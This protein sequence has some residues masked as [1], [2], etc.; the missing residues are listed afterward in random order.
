MQRSEVMSDPIEHVVIIVKEN[1]GFDTYFGRFP[2]CDGD[3][4]LANAANP[5]AVD[6]N[7]T[8]EGW[9]NRSTGAVAQQ[10]DEAEIAAYWAY[11]RSYTLCDRYFTDVAGPSTP[12]HLMLIAA[13]SPWVD[14]PHGGY[15]ITANQQIDLPS[16]PAQLE[17]AG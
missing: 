16:L 5:P 15:R 8:H 12:N 17:Q 6:P 3:G 1:H 13:D 11:A 7:H 10:Y 14:N 2:G 9:L 4:S